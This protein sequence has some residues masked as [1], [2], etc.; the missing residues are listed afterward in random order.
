MKK[1]LIAAAVLVTVLL[2]AGIIVAPA[3]HAEDTAGE[4]ATQYPIVLVHG[5]GFS[6]INLGINYWGRIPDYLGQRGAK[7][8]YGGTDGW[9]NMEQGAA[10]LKD[11][12]ERILVETG[13]EK[14]NIIAH[15][16]GG[17]D[18]RCM[19]S[20]LG[21]SGKVASLTTISSPHGGS[22]VLDY[23]LEQPDMLL[24]SAAFPTNLFRRAA[25]DR[26]PDFFSAV[27]E[28]GRDYTRAF[29]ETNPDKPG[30]YYQSFAGQLYAPA[31][32]MILCWLAYLIKMED[33]PNDGLVTVESAKWG[34][35]RGTLRGTWYRGVSHM[36]E[37]DFRR[38]DLDIVSVFGRTTIL[39]FYAAMVAELKQMG[40]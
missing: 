7:I 1:R 36:D 15:S 4:C 28:M 6:D 13:S 2:S 16:K 34:D 25:G 26:N 38:E 27:M 33:G 12:V 9:S 22:K 24:H 14:V 21:M 35:F 23:V 19:I 30:V 11:T 18:A 40:Y 10:D 8:F 29:N 20:S 39:G 17:L 31:S 5:A 32:D 3:A 37:V